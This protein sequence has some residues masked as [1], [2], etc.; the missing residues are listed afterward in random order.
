MRIK[1]T[2][3]KELKKEIER[4][5]QIL[6]EKNQQIIHLSS[7]FD[8]KIKELINVKKKIRTIPLYTPKSYL[9]MIKKE[10]EYEQHNK[11]KRSYNKFK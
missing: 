1:N 11:T 6:R 3:I 10:K 5:T 4:L 9:K 7:N 2:E 8:N